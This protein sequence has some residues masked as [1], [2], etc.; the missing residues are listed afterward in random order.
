MWYSDDRRF[1]AIPLF[2][3]H[4]PHVKH[5]EKAVKSSDCTFAAVAR[6]R[7]SSFARNSWNFMTNANVAKSA[8]RNL[9]RHC[10]IFLSPKSPEGLDVITQSHERGIQFPAHVLISEIS[11]CSHRLTSSVRFQNR[12]EEQF[13]SIVQFVWTICILSRIATTWHQVK[14]WHLK[15]V[16]QNVVEFSASMSLFHQHGRLFARLTNLI[17]PVP[18]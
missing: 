2:D 17:A 14:L 7:Y 13:C 3:S 9:L 12:L 10:F 4:A 18:I 1:P 6:C 11:I 8:D 16:G 15:G 5:L